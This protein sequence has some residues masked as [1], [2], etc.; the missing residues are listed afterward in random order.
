M[1]NSKQYWKNRYLKNGTSGSGSYN[2]LANFKAEIINNFV[3]KH[4]IQSI[5]DYGVGDG[6]QLKLINTNNKV[7]TG[8]DVSPFQNVKKYLKMIKQSVL[9][10]QII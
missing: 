7:Y 4:N 10:I 3:D 1:F 2:K 8:I 9:F 6:N 5:I